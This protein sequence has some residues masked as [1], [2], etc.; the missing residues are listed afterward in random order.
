MTAEVSAFPLRGRFARVLFRLASPACCGWLALLLALVGQSLRGEL[1]GFVS[2]DGTRL[3][4]PQGPLRFVSF[5]VPNLLVIEDAFGFDRTSPWR[6]PDDFELTD[7]FRS[8]RQMGATVARSYVITVRRDDSDMG[9]FVHV[10]G[11]GDFNEEAFRAMDRMLA[12][13]NREGVRVIVPLVDN[14]K[15]QGGGPQY[16][17]FR[18]RPPAAFWTDPEVIADFKQ[19]IAFVLTRRNT[20]TGL[21]YADDPAILGWETGNELDSPPAWTREIAATIKSFDPNHL[22]IDGNSLHGV[23]AASLAEPLID[24]VT[25]HHYPSYRPMADMV[26]EA[27]TAAAGRKPFF[28]GEAGFVPLADIR[29]VVERVVASEAAGVLLWSLRYRSRDGGFYWHSEPNNL[30][31]FKAYHWPGF[32]SG[33]AYDETAVMTLVR[34]AAHAIRGLPLVPLPRPE[35]PVMLPTADAGAISWQGSTGATH[36]RV[37][38]GPT[39]AGPWTVIAAEAREEQHQYRPL[40]A[41]EAVPIGQPCW[42]RAIAVNETGDSPP[43][44]PVGPIRM[45]HRP[46]VEEFDNLDRVMKASADV[47]IVGENPRAT[48]EDASRALLPPGSLIAYAMPEGSFML[49][50]FAFT[51]RPD[52]PLDVITTRAGVRHPMAVTREVRGE[53]GGDYGYLIPILFSVEL[54]GGTD[55]EIAVPDGAAVQLSRLEL[56]SKP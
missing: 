31:R 3:Q 24:V 42:Y 56:Y 38:R 46:F 45:Q 6:W 39:A 40:L 32:P 2:V 55:L 8:L 50:L 29:D 49:R 19:T 17:G 1:A 26:A 10:R 18:G 11:P 52:Q 21:R 53:A 25:T 33:N 7:A 12:A 9:E 43:A 35:P 13:A 27:I 23:Q 48:Q 22:V 36:Y 37:D 30:G 47:V 4:D 16:A 5:N 41:D 28:V 34:Q 14:W 54:A 51:E 15:W 44:L 20:I